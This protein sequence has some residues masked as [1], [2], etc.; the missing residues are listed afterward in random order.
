MSAKKL[1][2]S[3]ILLVIGGLLIPSGLVTNEYLRS[4]VS[5]GVPDALLGIKNE[6]VP[7]IEETVKVL[8]IPTI[9]L[10]IQDG[11]LPEIEN[12]VES[13]AILE[14][15][16]IVKGEV[17]SG[18]NDMV[19]LEAIPEILNGIKSGALPEIEKL[20]NL[21]IYIETLLGTKEEVISQMNDSVKFQAIPETLLGIKGNVVSQMN[22]SVKFQA[23][24]ET[25][26]GIK[27]QIIPQI[28]TIINASGAARAINS[29]ID[30]LSYYNFSLD[31]TKAKEHFFNNY[32]IQADTTCPAMGVSEYAHNFVSILLTN[33]SYTPAAQD[34]LLYGNST[35][36]L[37]GLITDLNLGSGILGFLQNYSL[38]AAG[39]QVIN[40]TMQLGYNATWDQ[41]E[42]LAGYITNYLYEYIVP[43]L[44]LSQMGYLPARLAEVYFYEQWANGT[45]NGDVLF[46]G[47]ID[48]GGGLTGFEVGIPDATN[49]SLTA[50][51]ILWNSSQSLA[52]VNLTNGLEVW[53]NT[54]SSDPATQAAAFGQLMTLGL[55]ANQIGN[56]SLWLFTTVMEGL[57]PIL[58]AD[59]IFGYGMTTTEYSEL[60][61]YEQWANCTVMPGGIDLGGGLMGLEVNCTVPTNISLTAAQALWNSSNSLAFVNL[62]DGLEVWAN[63]TS[64]D[65]ATQTAAFGLL[66]TLG[67]TAN[68]IGNVSLWLFT[69]V[70]EGLVPI[71]FADPILGYGMT[72]TEYSELLFYE[73]WANCTVMPGGIDLGGGLMGLEVNCTVPTNISLAITRDLWDPTNS[74][75]FTNDTYGL[76]I[77]LYALAEIPPGANYTLLK[78][79]TGLND[80]QMGMVLGWLYN[81]VSN[82]APILFYVEYGIFLEDAPEYAFYEQWANG[83]IFGEEMFPGGVDFSL[84]FEQIQGPLVGL[85]IGLPPYPSNVTFLAA[86]GL[87]DSMNSTSFTN[88]TIGFSKWK[89]AGIYGNT[90]ALGELALTFGLNAT[91]QMPLILNWLFNTIMNDIGPVL[92]TLPDPYG[93]GM[94][95][96]AYS[97]I[98]FYDQWANGTLFPTGLDLGYGSALNGLLEVGVPTPSGISYATTVVLW[99]DTSIYAFVNDT[100][101]QKWRDAATKLD[102]WLNLSTSLGLDVNQ[103]TL[104]LAWLPTIID[105]FVPA[106]FADPTLGYGM[107]ISAY[108]ET[109]FYE[110]WANGTILGEA[111][112]PQGID[113]GDGLTGFEV[114]IPTETNISLTVCQLLWNE[115]NG[116]TFV[117]D[118]GI[119]KWVDAATDTTVQTELST[120]F[121]LDATQLGEILDWLWEK[122]F[123]DDVVPILIAEELG[124]SVSEYAED[125]FFEQWAN[126]T[127]LGEKMFE[128]GIVLPFDNITGLEV[129]CPTASN[130]SLSIAEILFDKRN[131]SSLVD[132][133]GLQK[134]YTAIDKN[135]N[136]FSELKSTFGLSDTQ[137]EMVATWIVNFRDMV[138]PTLAKQEM[139]LP[140]DPY[141]LGTSIFLGMAIGGGILVALGVVVLILSR[142]T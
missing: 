123:K 16:K 10:G 60:L 90:T 70:M 129:G 42:I 126:C 142:R 75:S 82:V 104:M 93:K 19:K 81:W 130:I 35:Y 135:S 137:T 92:F 3:I 128:Q 100:G 91:T 74:S 1:S 140:A 114:G 23:I 52:F 54:T 33:L 25:L 26:L 22:D 103:M 121:G 96:M 117:N 68:Q 125:L 107:T 134:W 97:E 83:T 105:T 119:D 29:T 8:G 101:L 66:M 99:D 18:I 71:L 51:E 40:D 6:V 85:E 24:P 55:T 69:T 43:V 131:T 14:I 138:V 30:F 28:Y 56:V 39:N 37:E 5:K 80:T 63:T 36:G 118:T 115:A 61:F 78:T 32:T 34:Y 94:T 27:G 58:F 98:L 21:T 38:A 136:A 62:T 116:S 17:V 65:P 89:Q 2:A 45:I 88:I 87:W 7:E 76:P 127:I 133:G 86:Q 120:T 47:G 49:I 113:L 95:T 79:T 73:Q 57:V 108:A 111:I 141:T 15:L 84:F 41:I 50:A 102:V 72:T 31:Y 46:P 53:Y 44:T 67:L 77:W 48:L 12:M 132:P 20:L 4:E 11:A 110:Q 13:E 9:L 122:S 106:L 109:L 139:G 59:P 64:S 112:Y 124:M